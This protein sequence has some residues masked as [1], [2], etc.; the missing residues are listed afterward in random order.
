MTKAYLKLANGELFSGYSL[1][2]TGKSIGE[3]VFTTGMT[4]YTEILTDPSYLGQIVTMTYPL[5]GNYGVNKEDVEC[6]KSND[7]NNKSVVKGFIMREYCEFPS[8]FRNKLSLDD[9]LKEQNIIA[10]H[11]IDTRRL[12]KVIRESGVMNGVIYSEGFEP[13]DEDIKAVGEYIIKDAVKTVTTD[14]DIVL[15]AENPRFNVALLDFGTKTNI[16]RELLNRGCNV[17]IKNAFTKPSDLIGKF[18]G[19][20]L[21]NGPGDPSENVEIIENLKELTKSNTPIFGICLGHQLLSLACGLK[22]N[23]LKYGHRGAN[24]PV[25]DLVADRT[26]I[27]SQ[28][29]GYAVIKPD[30]DFK[31]ATVSHVHVNDETVSGIVYNN[32]PVFS[33]QYHPEAC[34]GPRDSM[35]LFDKFI[36]LMEGK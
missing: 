7:S 6:D 3:V 13:T 5:I 25:K 31:E 19:I 9:F 22:T 34:S 30:A 10:L 21:S 36:N 23:K 27:T 8:N 2:A 11:G 33:V 4:G 15:K 16:A 18:D 32:Y 17:T 20:M 35:Y 12:T 24:H 28:N 14:K 29:H 1:G 26:Y